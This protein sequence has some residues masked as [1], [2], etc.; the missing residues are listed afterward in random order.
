V[1][2]IGL[3]LGLVA[4]LA[5]SPK[6]WVSSRYY[7]LTPVLP[8]FK[9]LPY[10]TDYAVYFALIALLLVLCVAPR[11]AVFAG[12][13]ALIALLA[14]QDQSRWQPWFYQYVLMLLA[15]ALAGNKREIDARNA[16]RLIVAATYFWSGL[17]KLNP[18]FIDNFFP[19]LVIPVVGAKPGPAQW[20]IHDLGFVAPLFECALG[21]GLL[22]RRFRN[23]AVCGAIAMHV[24]ILIALGPW[25]RN[26][27]AV[28][29]P[30]N[31]AMI[32]FLWML[33]L[34]RKDD[35]AARD[36]LLARG[37]AFHQIVLVLLAILP[38]L[39]FL[40]LWDH[41]LSSALYSANRNAGVIYFD[42]AVFYR[43]PEPMDD[44]VT[45]ESPDRNSLNINN[46]SFD[47]LNV[48]S[49]PEVR[50]YKNVARSICRLGDVELVINH[51]LA[52]INSVGRTTYRCT[53][54][55]R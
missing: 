2:R 1:L 47:E 16:C 20:V 54:L 49:Y 26:F 52:L 19:A 32:A 51:K 14:L 31:L 36:I 10:P 15:I 4:G 13:F 42:D 39:S 25:G 45:D 21:V 28:I 3:L 30:W 37:F 38:A 46:W 17:A 9:P 35:P 7:P 53:D 29:W 41:Y 22:M 8:L 50:I 6:L 43:L 34:Q 55:I 33:F 48:P 27:N 12:A 23:A 24:F 40:N 11:R 18:N 44:Y 5:L